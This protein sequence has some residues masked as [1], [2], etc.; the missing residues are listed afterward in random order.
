M[1]GQQYVYIAGCHKGHIDC[2]YRCCSIFLFFNLDKNSVQHG[3]GE[4]YTGLQKQE[5]NDKWL[6][7]KQNLFII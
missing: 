3:E 4:L 1:L 5:I 7:D 6:I 2:V